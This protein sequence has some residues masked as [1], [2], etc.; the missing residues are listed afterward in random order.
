MIVICGFTPIELG[1][2]LA[3]ETHTFSISC[4]RCH[5]SKSVS[6]RPL[7]PPSTGVG[8]PRFPHATPFSSRALQRAFASGQGKAPVS[9]R[10]VLGY[11]TIEGAKANG[12]DGKVGS[13]TP[14]KKADIVMLRATDLNLFPV[15]DQ[16]LSITDQAHAGNVD[17]VIIDGV[18]RKR[19]GKRLF[20][21]A[22]LNQRRAE[23]VASVER[24]M[25]EGEFALKAA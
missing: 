2:T 25:R 13:L 6:L 23:L 12:L 9:A 11:A 17:T 3:S 20:P 14:G 5:R 24:I 1:I 21:D 15:H 19:Q 22:V 10:D 18:I 8:P 7:L 16:L 4:S